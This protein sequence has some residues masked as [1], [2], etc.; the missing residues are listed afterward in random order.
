MK[1]PKIGPVTQ[2]VSELEKLRL[3]VNQLNDNYLRSLAEFDNFR[4]RKERELVDFREFANEQ[5]LQ[6]LIPILDNLDRAIQAARNGAETTDRTDCI[7]LGIEMVARQLRET[8]NRFGFQEFSC[9]GE[10]FDPKRCEAVAFQETS[11]Q[12][13]GIVIAE[14]AK[15]YMYRS[16]V[17]RPAMVVVAKPPARAV[18]DQAVDTEEPASPDSC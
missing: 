18:S 9:L 13:D 3:E 15:G 1:S 17:L 6:E 2:M 16:R 4:R 5:L 8:L 11:D 14:S 10:E 12:A 7:C